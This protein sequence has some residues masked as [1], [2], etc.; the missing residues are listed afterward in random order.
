MS[1]KDIEQIII[2]V[3]NEIQIISGRETIPMSSATCAIGDLPGFDSL[4]G[5]E[6][7]LDISTKLGY[8]FDVDNLL[9][10]E[11]G[12]RALTIGEIAERAR[13]L[14]EKAGVAK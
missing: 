11:E 13:D 10:A 2:D 6:A 1:L 7:T 9:V 12:H 8:D 14:M 3:L 5:I 4:N